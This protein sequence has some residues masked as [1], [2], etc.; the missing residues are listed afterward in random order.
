MCDRFANSS[1]RCLPP[2][3]SLSSGGGRLA[4]SDAE[5]WCRRRSACQGASS[6]SPPAGHPS[7]DRKDEQARQ[8]DW[9]G[10][11]EDQQSPATD[12][13][14]SDVGIPCSDITSILSV[15]AEPCAGSLE[16]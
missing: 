1:R 2:V 7:H 12:P 3:R 15:T 8:F 5:E 9:F 16:G 4:A 14:M 13:Q 6:A 10:G 11:H